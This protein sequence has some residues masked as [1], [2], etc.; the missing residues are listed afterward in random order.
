M[1]LVKVGL[2]SLRSLNTVQAL[3]SFRKA[4]S[5]AA[6]R[7][8]RQAEAEAR[9]ASSEAALILG[10]WALAEQEAQSVLEMSDLDSELWARA[11]YNMGEVMASRGDPESAW[12]HYQRA[13]EQNPTELLRGQT[14]CRLAALAGRTGLANHARDLIAELLQSLQPR[15]HEERELAASLY[16]QLGLCH[17]RHSQ[18]GQAEEAFRA[19][20]AAL[21]GKS[22]L[23]EAH[24][25]RYLGVVESVRGHHRRALEL[26]LSAHDLFQKAGCRYGLARTYESIGRTYLVFNRLEE[27]LFCLKRSASMCEKLGAE[28]EL[29]TIYG[30]LGHV[31]FVR[32]EYEK[33][34]AYFRRD[35]KTATRF[36]NDYALGFALRNLGRCEAALGLMDPAVEHLLESLLQFEKVRDAL[37]LGRVQMD[38]CQAYTRADRLEEARQACLGARSLMAQLGMDR[39]VAY[40]NLLMGMVARKSGH[41]KQ[42]EKLLKGSTEALASSPAWLAEAYFELGELYRESKPKAA[43]EA[44]QNAF[45]TVR[46]AGL[47]REEGRYLA[48]L[49]QFDPHALFATLMEDVADRDSRHI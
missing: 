4:A 1:E 39:E 16:N 29:A 6:R 9:N 21:K 24:A 34:A 44:Y 36:K 11:F 19:A 12:N 30:K 49:E 25:R 10:K 23:E 33:A 17:L 27:A 20:L 45:R 43:L 13:L 41:P 38:L 47:A 32:E 2:R 5:N 40:L 42:A 15:T 35:L 46:R 8:D 37:N 48:A 3:T 28:A 18:L 7:K 14:I 26:H 22:S 31:H